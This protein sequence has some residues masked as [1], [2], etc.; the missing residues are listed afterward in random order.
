MKRVVVVSLVALAL[1]A[2]QK[3][4]DEMTWP[5][6]KQLAQEIMAR[7]EKD[8]EKPGTPLFDACVNSY[9][10]QEIT[11]RREAK[12]RSRAAGLILAGGLANAGAGYSAAAAASRPVSCT[13]NRFGSTVTTNCY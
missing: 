4:V 2:C 7:C 9:V 8:G 1:T 13:S 10:N 12:N 6:K 11:Q 5:E 3:T